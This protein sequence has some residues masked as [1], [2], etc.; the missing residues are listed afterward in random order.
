VGAKIDLFDEQLSLTLAAFRT[1]SANA[2][3]TIDAD[4]VA[5]IG[6]KR[7]NGIEFGFNGRITRQWTVFGGYSYL[8]AKIRD[9]GFSALTAAA[10][11]AQP[12][13]T[14]YVPSVN[15]GRQFPQTA[16][17]S[18]TAWTNYDVTPKLSL[19]GGAF[20]MSRVYGGYADNRSAVQDAAGVVTITPATT[21][22]ARSIPSYWR[23][24][25]RASYRLTDTIQISVN[26]QNL[27]DKRYFSQ[28][29]ASHYA[30]VAPG[31]TV[32]GTI[33]LSY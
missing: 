3:V 11:G 23:F 2:R 19:G 24:D 5:F 4:T 26:A 22:V 20:Y 14:V 32:F 15:T 10:V 1:E 17:H 13:Q 33:S 25:A 12:V 8:D 18:F 16:K 9:G 31:R 21:T 7:A 6:K 27:T 29:Y 30:S 28:A